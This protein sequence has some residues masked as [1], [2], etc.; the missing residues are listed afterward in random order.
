MNPDEPLRFYL[1]RIAGSYE[2]WS[3]QPSR[4][5]SELSGQQAENMV[6]FRLRDEAENALKALFH[7]RHNRENGP[8]PTAGNSPGQTT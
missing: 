2:I 6:S 4:L 8:V 7:T 1:V 3:L 5:Q